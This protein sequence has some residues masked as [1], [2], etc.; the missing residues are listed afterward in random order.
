[1]VAWI[2]KANLAQPTPTRSY[3]QSLTIPATPLSAPP[4]I[5]TP[6]AASAENTTHRRVAKLIMVT[7]NNNN[8]YY[9]M[10]ETQDGR[11]TVTYGRVGSVGAV[12]TY[13]IQVWELKRQE[14]LRKGYVDQTHL[15]AKGLQTPEFEDI[16]DDVV[17]ELM[18]SLMRY[19]NKS[20]SHHYNVTADQVT[21]Q[22]V[23][24]AQR[25]LNDLV[26]QVSL[27][28]N[29]QSFN[30]QLIQLFK[31]IPR[32]MKRVSD[33][34]IA[35]PETLDALADIRNQL[36]AEQ[37]TLD[38]MRGQVEL[39][40]NQNTATE[41]NIHLLEALGLQLAPLTDERAIADIKKMMGVY[42]KSFRRAYQVVNTRTQQ[43]F[44]EYLAQ[45]RSKK[46]TLFWHGSRNENWFSI[47]KSGLVLRP[48]NAV[49]TGK[50]FGYGLYFADQFRKSLNYTSLHGSTWANGR[51]KQAFLALYD[52]HV[53]KQLKI[54]HHE[55]WCYELTEEKLR[56]QGS[57][58]DSLFAQGGADL[59]NNE[60]IIYNERQCTVRYL[61]EV[62]TGG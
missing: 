15:F 8:K 6:P 30:E 27:S 12:K 58:Y 19:A 28:M 37:E 59:V 7:A 61:V 62:R 32:R 24:E 11:F 39:K 49:I 17:R 43:Q 1:M 10:Q 18:Q 60:Y 44:T 5:T 52:V 46:N 50:M 3:L 31:I 16:S 48:A 55:P 2:K 13:P 57:A 56:E 23:E 14:K 21:A 42:E 9:E 4:K 54:K 33:H 35:A 47:L 22:Q 25:I 40:A 51:D 36:G 29:V 45:A 34:L 53:G 26:G 41:E 38:V 20:I